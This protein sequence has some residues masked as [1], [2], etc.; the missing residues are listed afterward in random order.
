M[1]TLQAA[2][3]RPSVLQPLGSLHQVVLASSCLGPE[4]VHLR[5]RVHTSDCIR[6]LFLTL[7]HAATIL[8]LTKQQLTVFL[9]SH[10][11]LSSLD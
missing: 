1:Y 11:R 7:H 6:R 2:R 4:H 9:M 10:A 8:R 5:L 3:I